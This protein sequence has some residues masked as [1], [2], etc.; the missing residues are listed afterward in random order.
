MNLRGLTAPCTQELHHSW[1]CLYR[2]G[3]TYVAFSRL[4]RITSSQSFSKTCRKVSPSSVDRYKY[5]GW[6]PAGRGRGKERIGR[7]ASPLPSQSSVPLPSYSNVAKVRWYFA[8]S[9]MQLTQSYISNGIME[10]YDSTLYW[11]VPDRF[12]LN[13]LIHSRT[14]VRVN[15]YDVYA[16]YIHP[17]NSRERERER[18]RC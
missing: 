14:C 4:P 5:S 18:D 6:W 7:L 12:L 8:S 10:M 9:V 11:Q 15:N 3:M 1:Y 2:W 17:R 13:F 16:I